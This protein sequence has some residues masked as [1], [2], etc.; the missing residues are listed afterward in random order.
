[1]KVRKI[2]QR[3]I[4]GAIVL[5][6]AISMVAVLVYVR[7]VESQPRTLLTS[8][9]PA[10]P[11]ATSLLEA[12][13][14]AKEQA[15]QWRDDAVL[16]Q[17]RS[18]D[19]HEAPSQQSGIDGK[20]RSWQA[21]AI[22]PTA[23]TQQL[24]LDIVDGAVTEATVVAA[25][26]PLE[27]LQEPRVDSP[28]AVGIA[29]KA[30]PGFG[31]SLDPKQQGVHF[32]LGLLEEGVEVIQVIGA[33]RDQPAAVTIE[34]STGT[35]K[36][37][38]QRTYAGT[39]GV[40]FSPDQG[41]TWRASDLVGQMVTAIANDPTRDNV[42]YASIAQSTGI[43]V[44]RTSDGGAH[45]TEV[46]RLPETAGTW[47]YTIATIQLATASHPSL[48]V[49]TRTGLWL[50]GDQG[51]TW[52]LVTG[53]SAGPAWQVAAVDGDRGPKVFVSVVRDPSNAALYS[54]SDL[55]NWIKEADGVFRLSQSADRRSILA[56]SES[57][58]HLGRLYL[59][60]GELVSLPFPTNTMPAVRMRGPALRAAGL[61]NSSTPILV[62]SPDGI[63]VSSDNGLTWH[64]TLQVG[65]ASV[66]VSPDFATSGIAVAGGF[67][68]GIF[69]SGDWGETWTR[70]IERPST[71]VNGSNEITTV[72]FLSKT[73]AVAV[74]GGEISWQK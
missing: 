21:V 17:L 18:T 6:A 62:E 39:G 37:A 64:T 50:S 14:V 61:F 55:T 38:Q 71:I 69:W 67:R 11:K 19:V 52:A 65:L 46:G 54:S 33:I 40:L 2:N 13:R 35:L 16:V 29:L 66:A 44:Y 23:S 70:V 31:G 20:R 57:Q 41:R 15:Q 22:S 53:L 34:A 7:T 8:Q 59:A 4:S 36:G 32:V 26:S 48:L 68:T 47:P 9:P 74:N 1:M 58:Q 3:T 30:I 27:V 42:G 49:G 43:A 72:L 60:S 45:W 73:N 51:K 28:E 12:W 5:I 25:P 63:H 10:E 24:R 56:L